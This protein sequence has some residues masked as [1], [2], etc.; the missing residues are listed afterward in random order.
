MYNI[1]L[2]EDE[3]IEVAALKKIIHRHIDGINIFEANR[4]S[5]AIRFIDELDHIDL[6]L[7]DINIPLPNGLEVIRYLRTKS[8][9]TKV[10]VTTANDDIAMARNM[11]GLKVDDYLLKPIKPPMLIN[12][13]KDSLSF[14]E[15]KNCAL[16]NKKKELE[17]LIDNFQY[18]KWTSLFMEKLANQNMLDSEAYNLEITHLI[19]ILQQIIK[20]RGW[21]VNEL[22]QYDLL[23]SGVKLTKQNYYKTLKNLINI[24]NHIFDIVYKKLGSN[25]NAIQ[26]AQYYIGKN[27]FNSI[28]L[29]EVA[30]HA[31]VSSCYLSRLY[32]KHFGIGFSEYFSRQKIE[33]AK[34]LL[35]FSDLQVNSIA[36]ELAYN[37]VNYFCR[38]FKK[39]VGLSPSEYRRQVG[40]E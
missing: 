24:S 14:D 17:E 2:V 38:L 34:L 15:Q 1:V 7:V 19:N 29:D 25:L 22:K 13:I 30:E 23:L 40:V 32:K 18:M 39:E 11:F 10:I 28:R 37:D 16:K 33:L 8:H 5:D 3:V 27:I 26:R 36:L 20:E 6:M 35:R 9:K 31:Y 4:G 12:T 21:A